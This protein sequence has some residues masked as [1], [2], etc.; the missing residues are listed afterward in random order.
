MRFVINSWRKKSLWLIMLLPL[1]Y[2]FRVIVFFRKRLLYKTERPKNFTVPIVVIGNITVGGSG[3][4]PLTIAI[5][6]KLVGLGYKPG[7]VSRGYKAH[8]PH[9]PFSVKSNGDATFTGDEPLMIAKNTQSPVVIDTNRSRAVRFIQ[10]EFDVDVI[11]SD[12]GLQHYRMYRDV[13]I[14][15]VGENGVLFSRDFLPA[16]PLREPLN[17]LEEVD[18]IVLNGINQNDISRS[19]LNKTYEMKM[20]PKSFVNLTTNEVKPF[21][22]APFNIGNRIQA[23]TAI[24]NPN[25]FFETLEN[26]P[27]PIEKICYPDHYEFSSD[28]FI[29]EKIDEHQPVVMTEKDAVKCGEFANNNFWMLTTNTELEDSFFDALTGQ[30]DYVKKDIAEN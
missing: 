4:T 14:C 1:A 25:R 23:V 20:I 15:V 17:R 6:N 10:N 2:L 3:K 29:S 9:Y 5:A 18:L 30:I 26:L 19:L 21:G 8:A 16:G 12:D 24:A 28:D 11:L 27:Y 7:I 22:G 13:E